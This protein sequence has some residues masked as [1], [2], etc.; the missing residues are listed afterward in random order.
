MVLDL[1]PYRVAPA[2]PAIMHPQDGCGKDKHDPVGM[3]T[4]A[5][6][7]REHRFVHA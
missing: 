5:P 1:V 7:C 2:E 6:L 4:F 3:A